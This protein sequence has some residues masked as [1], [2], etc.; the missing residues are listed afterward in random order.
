M[1][2]PENRLRRRLREA[3]RPA[4]GTWVMSTSPVVAEAIGWA[5]FDFA[6]VD[7]EHAPLDFGSTLAMLQALGGTGTEVIVRLP[8]ADPVTVKKVLD[9]GAQTV[10]FPMIQSAAEARAAVA[11]TR[12]PPAGIRGVAAFH[13]ASR[14][15]TIGQYLAR[16]DSEI[17]VILQ[18]ETP[19]AIAARAEIMA[20]EGVDAVFVGPGDLSAAMGHI[21]RARDEAVQAVLRETAAAARA[22]G[23]PCG[24]VGP[25]AATVKGYE[26]AGFSFVAIG[27]DLGLMMAAARAVITDLRGEREAA[28]AESAY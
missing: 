18:L 16:A 2:I 28:E 26:A 13:R 3:G 11:A 10:M 6:V 17:A 8:S 14:Y 19:Q 7:M 25:D 1:A 27:S 20:V 24:I 12:Y 23:M 21:G 22:R 15:G 4:L 5:G 9:I